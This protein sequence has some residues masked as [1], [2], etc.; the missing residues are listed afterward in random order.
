MLKP[1]ICLLSIR[2]GLGPISTFTIACMRA[3]V[4]VMTSEV[5]GIDFRGISDIDIPVG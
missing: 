3:C 2:H 5:R 1:Y 4:K